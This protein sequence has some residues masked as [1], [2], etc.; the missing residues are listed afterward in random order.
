[1]STSD[2]HR[3]A[4]APTRSR[5]GGVRLLG[6]TAELE[7]VDTLLAGHGGAGSGLV[8]RGGPGVGKTALLDAAAA[9]AAGLGRRVLRAS[10]AEFEAGTAFSALHQLLYPLRRDID[11]LAAHHRDALH[12]VL[13][14]AQPPLPAPVVSTAVLALLERITVER[15]LL[16]IADDVAWFDPASAAVLGFVVRRIADTMV[17][18]LAAART[19]TEA[20]FHQVRLPEHPVEPLD[21]R[22]AAEV[23]DAHAPGLAPGVRRR[24][25][26]EAEGNPLALLELPLAL[27]DRQRSGQDPLPA[28]LPL[29]RRLETAFVVPI[30]ELPAPTRELLLLAALAPEAGLPLLR[31]A[32]RGS[33]E[34]EDLVPAERAGLIHAHALTGAVVFRHPLIASATVQ[35]TP[36]PELRAA[37]EALAAALSAAPERRAWHLAEAATG[38]D[39]SV[40]RALD[41][42]AL[43]VWR[44][45]TRPADGKQALNE[46]V[47]SDRGRGATS[48]A[49]TALMRAG[50]LTPH[51]VD[52]SRRL[53][54]AAFLATMTGQLDQV[55][56]LLAEA[57]RTPD[58]PTG[59]VLAVTAHL[60]T[61]DEG[62]VDAAFRLLA[63]ALDHSSCGGR[64][65]DWNHLGI[66]YALLLVSLYAVGPEPWALLDATMSRFPAETVTVFRLCH[67]AYVDPGRK[68]GEIREGLAEAFAALPTDAAPWQLVPLAFAAVAMD[69][70]AEYRHLLTRM[71]ERERDGGAIAM[72]IPALI[73]LCHD[74]YIHG[75]WDEAQRLEQE[76]LELASAY[77]YHFWEHQVRALLALSAAMRGE[78][79]LARV[80][81]AETTNWA[82]PRGMGVTEGYA[83]SARNL[84]ALGEGDFEEAFVQAARIDP[85]GA[86]GSGVPGRWVV[87]DFVEAAV[88]TGR[89]EEARAHVRAAREA[90]LPAIGP[91][92]ALIV[93]GA[94][95]VAADDEEAG[96]LYEAALT[97]PEASRWPWEHARVQFAYGQWLRRTHDLSGARLQLGAALET[98]RRMG[99]ATMAQRAAGELRATGVSVASS[100]PSADVLTTQERQIAELAATGLSNK[101]IGER[102]FLSHRTV[103]SHLY[104][105]YPKLGITSRAALRGALEAMFGTGKGERAP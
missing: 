103:G 16:M 34:A 100:D 85:P 49:V 92:I 66:L 41:E 89:V 15:E 18:F 93:E 96:A 53:V 27:T 36:P 44:R 105:M 57:G 73:L 61:N 54:E 28:R 94:A 25:L 26:A 59:L 78:M 5:S 43:A 31:T 68:S 91:R 30:T 42:A 13:G 75:E 14:L 33:A 102:L 37:H 29:S 8:L 76:A 52:R 55:D 80:R 10:G 104:R 65:D 95:A 3:R 38:P 47:V 82:V 2:R 48:A 11:A 24:L 35:M 101:Q 58:S 86:P 19:G 20:L 46:R 98:F 81:S 84:A 39:E 71:V 69:T 45:G 12:Q 87:L 22:S 56:R 88:R 7:L 6:R 60:L 97:L 72:V 64:H 32:A 79:D 23:L 51:P 63:R 9:R 21:G 77:G 74:S 99:A 62:N 1:M 83:R 50:E 90:G 67:D 40:A 70:L 4:A 17:V